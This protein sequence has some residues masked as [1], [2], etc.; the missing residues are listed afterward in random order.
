MEKLT[1]VVTPK[2]GN[3][4]KT[5]SSSLSSQPRKNPAKQKHAAATASSRSIVRLGIIGLGNMGSYHSRLLSRGA[6]PGCE[7]AAVCDTEP[8][9]LKNATVPAFTGSTE[10]IRSGKVDAV[11]IATPHYFHIPIGIEALKAGLHVIVEKPLGVHKAD[12]ER[13]LRAHTNPRQ[14]FAIMLNQRTDPYYQ[15]LRQLVQRGEFGKI[16]RVHWTITDWFRTQAY[17]QSSIWRA[18]WAGEGGGALLNQCVHNIDLF[19]WIFGMP[20]TVRSLCQLGRYH[21]IE[22]ED[23]V[24]AIFEYPD[25]TTATLIASTGEAPGINRLEIAGE[26]GLAVL[27][28]AKLTFRRNEVQMSEF[29]NKCPEHYAHPPCWEV[30]IPLPNHRGE[31]HAG[32]LKNFTNAIL[33][34]EPLLSPAR[35][36]LASVELINAI[37]MSSLQDATIDL[38]IA[39]PAYEKLLKKLV[40]KSQL[41]TKTK[42]S[43]PVGHN[44]DFGAS[45]RNG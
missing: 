24:S 1:A 39:A 16:R 9:R 13:L 30:T 26:Q 11:L 7:L 3:H 32:I 38:P 45:S 4:K 2:A 35:D 10:M 41:R 37:L 21:S 22:V 33:H 12:C 42:S 43:R 40:S 29:S 27:E 17:Y 23:T 20:S 5:S 44:H 28:G 19:Q 6:I 8:D 31:Q 36:G 25:R 34:G 15:K 14:V 18:T